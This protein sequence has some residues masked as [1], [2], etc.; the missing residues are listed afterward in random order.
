[1]IRLLL[2]FLMLLSGCTK[3]TE[4]ITSAALKPAEIQIV[5]L[6]V[7]AKVETI[8]Y[9]QVNTSF[10][11]V[12]SHQFD[13][14]NVSFSNRLKQE[15]FEISEWN[16]SG[17][18]FSVSTYGIPFY[19]GQTYQLNL[20][21]SSSIADAVKVVFDDY[22]NAFYEKTYS[23][24]NQ[25]QTIELKYTHAG[26]NI[27]DGVMKLVF[28]KGNSAV[29]GEIVIEEMSFQ[30]LSSEEHSVKVNQ[31]GYLPESQKLAVFRYNSGDWFDVIDVNTN[32]VVY[33]GQITGRTDNP[34]ADEV[35]YTGDFSAV[36]T[37][38]RYRIVSQI[39]GR[40]V[41]F[42]IGDQLYAD[43]L[44]DSLKMITLQRCGVCLD[45]SIAPGFEH[46]SC[47][48]TLAK[49]YSSWSDLDVTGGWHDAGDY[50]RYTLTAV[51]T[52]SDLLLAYTVYPESFSDEM[53][54][55]ESG[56]GIPDVVDEA[57]VG[58]DWLM[59]MQNSWGGVYTAAVTTQFADFVLP[60]QDQQQLWLLDEENTSTAS[61][62]GA[63]AMGYLVIKEFDEEKAEKYLECAIK[64][65]D[66]AVALRGQQDKKNPKEIS[67][68]DYGNSSDEDE[69]YFA[70][71][72]LY[73]AT[74]E[75][76]YLNEIKSA[77]TASMNLF[78]L[79]Y[80]VFSGYGSY[81]LLKDE[82][83][84]TTRA[85]PVLYN[86]M[87][88]HGQNLVWDN[89][90]DGYH[91]T[92]DSYHWGANMDV[93]NNAMMMLLIHDI[94]PSDDLW[95]CAFEQLSYLLGKNSINTSF[96]SGYGTNYPKQ[97]HHRIAEVND[98]ILT[99]A[100][101]GGPDGTIESDLPPAKKYWDDSSMY[102]TNEVAIYYNSPLV[103]VVS[104]FQ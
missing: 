43:L 96:V 33:T 49:G 30:H 67:A 18:T 99:G 91:L 59:K 2:I 46:E 95:N 28:T 77:L 53:G 20:T 44:K 98:I 37:P 72:L 94:E 84:K 101:V 70:S 41:E 56:N 50:G 63:F 68:G 47:H 69:I 79:S 1:M 66:T 40:S 102:S 58:L 78:G 32:E 6:D 92:V 21:V 14:L 12:F 89:V 27:S 51:K 15:R 97:I 7:P 3:E 19:A 88:V 93:A 80:D 9:A 34:D 31:V 76:Q 4:E 73:V 36:T 55:P 57:I 62:S 25:V 81:F 52:M 87:A 10:S 42:V 11:S 45:E 75:V 5:E 35:N 60:D 100:L 16:N 23:I 82:Q 38:G 83:F 90:N 103:F 61:A 64:A 54:L 22:T 74:H 39:N 71:A 65:Y 29:S 24:G 8:D 13:H 104:A 26:S 86:Q 48:H 17:H 85:Y